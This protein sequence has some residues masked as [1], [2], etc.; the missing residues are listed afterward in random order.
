MYNSEKETFTTSGRALIKDGAQVLEAASVDFDEATGLGLATGNVVWKDT[1]NNVT[2]ICEQ[3]VYDKSTD[4]ILASGDRPMLITKV[5]DDSLYLTADTLVSM[6]VNPEDSLRTLI[7]YEDVRIFK[8]D[9]QAV[10]D[11]MRYSMADS[12]FQFYKNPLIWSDT[13]QFSADTINMFLADN[14]I[15]RILLYQK[16]MIVNSPDDQIFNQIKGKYITAYFVDD[17]L[18]R[19]EVNG[20]AETVYYMQEE[21]KSYVG[22]NKSICSEML[23]YFGNNEIEDIKFY[24][25][26]KSVLT[27]MKLADHKKMRLEGFSW[28]M[29]RRP[30][31]VEDLMIKL[32][33]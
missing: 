31:S 32:P 13:T 2:I 33:N 5:D 27:P 7:A 22:V 9:M 21:D 18:N 6:K 19:M 29:N 30:K 1:A 26:P 11:S 16:S 3:A 25:Q 12:V 15:D 8:S 17:E 4:Y 23:I 28:Q 24:K 10:C 20:N 14:K